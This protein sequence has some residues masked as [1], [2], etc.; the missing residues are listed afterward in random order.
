MC[1]KNSN[2]N[3]RDMRRIGMKQVLFGMRVKRIFVLMNWGI[4]LIKFTI[5]KIRV[6]TWHSKRIRQINERSVCK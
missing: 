5:K 1:T 6:K 3:L 2:E 4:W